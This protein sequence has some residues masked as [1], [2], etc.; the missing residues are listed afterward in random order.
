M[1]RQIVLGMLP[2]AVLGFVVAYVR[3]VVGERRA[4]RS[5]G[6]PSRPRVWAWT[7]AL[8]ILGLVVGALVALLSGM[9]NG[10]DDLARSAMTG[11]FFFAPG[12]V[13]GLCVGLGRWLG[14]RTVWRGR[15]KGLS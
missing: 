7:F 14:S 9:A 13:V 5:G 15:A 4:K 8:G 6:S 1:R 3:M 12:L 11:T 10:S 2:V